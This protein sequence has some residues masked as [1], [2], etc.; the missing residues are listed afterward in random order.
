MQLVKI[1]KE[2]PQRN[3]M[4]DEECQAIWEDK[5]TAYS[6]T[7]NRNNRQNEQEYKDKRKEVHKIFRQIKTVLFKSMLEEMEVAYNNSEAVK[8]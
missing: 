8:F 1:G 3:N 6:K 7:I 2:R 5:T 4:F